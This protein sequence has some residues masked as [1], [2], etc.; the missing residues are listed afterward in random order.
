MRKRLTPILCL[1]LAVALPAAGEQ[2]PVVPMAAERLP[3]LNTPRSGCVVALAP[4]GEPL[5][6]GGHTTGF[7]LTQTAEYYAAGA[8][9]ELP[10]LYPHD[11][12]FCLPLRSGE[13]LVG[14]GAA[15]AFGIGQSWGVEAY[16]PG[17]HAFT[18]KP[19]L[20]RKRMLASAT[21]L[22]D[23]AI[24]VSG[25]WY[26]EDAVGVW[27]PGGVFEA[28]GSVSE[29][30]CRPR[31]LPTGPSD[32]IIFGGMDNY[33]NVSRTGWVDRLNGE[34][35]QEPLLTEWAPVA[36]LEDGSGAQTC[37]IGD[38]TY[39]LLGMNAD[40]QYAV[41]LVR[42]EE[43]SLL[44]LAADIP[45]TGADATIRYGGAV[46][47][48]RERRRA[49]VWGEAAQ[50]HFL[51]C[52]DYGTALD[53]GQAP[54]TLYCVEQAEAAWSCCA[55]T[56]LPDGSLLG[57]GGMSGDNYRPVAAVWRYLPDGCKPWAESEQPVN[58]RA[59]LL[60]LFVGL[61]VGEVAVV[62]GVFLGRRRFRKKAV[63]MHQDAGSDA[64]REASSMMARITALMEEQQLFRRPGLTLHNVAQALGT[65][66]RYVSACINDGT[67]KSFPDYIN[68]YRVRYAQELLKANPGRPLSGV[69]EEAGF[70]GES[71]FFRNFKALTGK[72]PNQWLM[73]H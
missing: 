51:L 71:S 64:A 50:E 63:A 39:L 46:Y 11:Y 30:R 52:I 27:R 23:G 49:W 68:G 47:A 43:F 60:G 10:M 61:L 36:M 21:E 5:V 1:L 14:A 33:G 45:L 69:A 29:A 38:Y 8:W 32:A 34:P 2:V 7:V 15:E 59:R 17:R 20:D 9:H 62:A 22:E 44:P 24:V 31:I 18:G 13:V 19:V 35:F 53:G 66:T 16:N 58:R 28:A 26:A 37:A 56:V 12:A 55:C 65:N 73:E 4:G 48:D 57:V 41:I 25:N 70:S 54:L 6:F 67:G 40:G 42:G 3:D 72:T